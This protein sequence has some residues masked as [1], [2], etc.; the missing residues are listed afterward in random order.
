MQAAP[1]LKASLLSLE[2]ICE[3]AWNVR[4]VMLSDLGIDLLMWKLG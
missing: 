1:A 4:K 3:A 2:V